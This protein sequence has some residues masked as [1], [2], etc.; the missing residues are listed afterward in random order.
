MIDT[1][2]LNYATG[3]FRR[4]QDRL[5]DECLEQRY[6]GDF[7][8]VNED[9][10]DFSRIPT[11]AQIPYGF[12]PAM[13]KLAQ[14]RGYRYLLWC[15]SS[16]VPVAPLKRAFDIIRENGYMFLLCGHNCGV[17]CSDAA[18]KTLGIT[19]EDAFDIPQIIGGCQGLDLNN[20]LAR[21]YLDRWYDLSR[22]GISFHG[23]HTNENH[24]VST[25]DRVKGSRHDQVAGS[26]IAHQLGMDRI[27]GNV[28]MYDESGV[29]PRKETTIFLVRSA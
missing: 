11:H 1:V 25:D 22:D 5:R 16:I 28:A 27:L 8:L 24:Q 21:D 7:Y 29:V 3:R 6:K 19:R 13:M 23:S 14:G 26:V 15:D 9:H 4:G 17:W 2:I 10:E 12:K 18:L 20:E